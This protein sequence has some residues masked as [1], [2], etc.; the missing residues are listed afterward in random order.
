MQK[1]KRRG[2]GEEPENAND[3]L[4]SN[5]D[6]MVDPASDQRRVRLFD[7]RPCV[8]VDKPPKLCKNGLG[9]KLRSRCRLCDSRT[10]FHVNPHV[11][12]RIYLAPYDKGAILSDYMMQHNRFPEHLILGSSGRYCIRGFYACI[13]ERKTKLL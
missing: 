11:C 12:P 4:P 1:K 7:P 9:F 6:A 13:V 10:R 5:P 3:S 8:W 2:D